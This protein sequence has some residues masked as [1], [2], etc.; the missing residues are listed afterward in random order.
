[1]NK[2]SKLCLILKFSGTFALLI[3][4]VKKLTIFISSNS[5]F[6]TNNFREKNLKELSR[7]KKLSFEDIK[8]KHIKDFQSFYNRIKFSL[9]YDNDLDLIPTDQRL[10]NFKKLE[11][12][13]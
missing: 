12:S 4:N 13:I 3:S 9:D 1:M 7:V 2:F 8:N 5:D 6:Y 10:K 11:K